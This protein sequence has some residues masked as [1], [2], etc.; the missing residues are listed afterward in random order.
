MNLNN[1]CAPSKKYVDNSCFTLESLIKI[2]NKY[3]ETH[4]DKININENKANLV[5]EIGNKLSKSCS[6]QVCW[7]RTDLL[8]S[9]NDDDIHI[10]TF[11]PSGPRERYEWLSTTHINDVLEQYHN[12]YSN[13]M[14][15][16]AV[17]YDFQELS[18]LGLNNIDF[19]DLIKNKKHKIGLVINL[20]E[21]NQRGSHWVALY[22]DL[23]K[24]K[25][26]FFDSVGK[27][28]GKKIKKFINNITD[29]LYKKNYGENINVGKDD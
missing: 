1:R 14:F 19:D 7:L 2:A 22:T 3:N 20:D 29:F 26:Y 18:V 23:L 28:P 5:K 9:I 16:G 15:L 8:K 10:N 13:F 6:D 4:T 11:R 25:I 17:P 24:N 12:K 27:P 21:H